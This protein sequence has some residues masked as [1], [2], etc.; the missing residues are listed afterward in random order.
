MI[1]LSNSLRTNPDA[2]AAMAVN[3]PTLRLSSEAAVDVANFAT[4]SIS[5]GQRGY[6]TMAKADSSSPESRDDATQ[7]RLWTKSLEW[8]KVSQEQCSLPLLL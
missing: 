3:D 4:N 5:P 2:V 6:F 1:D 8:A 7:D